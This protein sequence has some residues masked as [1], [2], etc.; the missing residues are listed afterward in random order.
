MTVNTIAS[1]N[2]YHLQGRQLRVS[3]STT[4]FGGKPLFSYQDANKSL[5]FSGDEIRVVDS[6]I[7]KL[8]TVTIALTV[9]VGSTTFTL[10]VPNVNLVGQLQQANIRTNGITTMHLFG[11]QPGFNKGQTELYSVA[12]LSGTAELVVS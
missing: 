10:L 9:D 8:V 12:A 4:S 2:T 1:P 6:G 7:G 5:S 3:Y 11:F